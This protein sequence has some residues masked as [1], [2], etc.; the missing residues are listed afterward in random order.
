M[1]I[2]EDIWI[3]HQSVCVENINQ[4]P[5]MIYNINLTE[6]GRNQRDIVGNR[7]E[8]VIPQHV[9][10][11]PLIVLCCLIIITCIHPVLIMSVSEWFSYYIII[12][13][14]CCGGCSWSCCL[15]GNDSIIIF[16]T[17]SEHLEIY[18]QYAPSPHIQ[19]TRFLKFSHWCIEEF[20]LWYSR[21]GNYIRLSKKRSLYH[22]IQTYGMSGVC[23]WS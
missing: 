8:N 16:M 12:L 7:D 15:G 23:I 14:S 6:H 13:V 21:H 20:C 10:S 5:D 19:S 11:S 4:K 9:H 22:Y 1:D 3:S 2:T 18:L 17:I